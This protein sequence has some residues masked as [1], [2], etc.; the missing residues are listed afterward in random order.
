MPDA[1]ADSTLTPPQTCAYSDVGSLIICVITSALAAL[2][3]RARPMPAVGALTLCPAAHPSLCAARAA[4]DAAA[5]APRYSPCS[6]CSRL[7]SSPVPHTTSVS[8]SAH[9]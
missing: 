9:M 7:S 5:P 3:W 2:P 6:I 8:A 4:G 1:G